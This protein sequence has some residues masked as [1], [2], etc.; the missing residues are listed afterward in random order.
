MDDTQSKVT[1]RPRSKLERIVEV[2]SG[3]YAVPVRPELDLLTQLVLLELVGAG[4]E[5]KAALAAIAGICVSPGVVDAEK[6]AAT[7]RSLVEKVCAP[8]NVDDALAAL[9]AT[10]AL[11]KESSLAEQ[12]EDDLDRARKLLKSIPTMTD[13]RADVALLYAAT[14][15]I[16]APGSAASRVAARIGYPGATYAALARA[17][18]EELPSPTAFNVAWRAHH[19]LDQLGKTLCAPQS[20]E[21]FRCPVREACA[22]H[23]I[24]ED[25][26]ARLVGR[27][28]P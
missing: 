23:G 9:R 24:G 12:C 16:V 17:L 7:P 26:A 8:T 15:A 21:C 25:P 1:L 10:G 20:P 27:T 13:H 5:P 18:D 14:Q 28:D 11:A 3:T 4:S 6:L 22:F 19:V 2:L